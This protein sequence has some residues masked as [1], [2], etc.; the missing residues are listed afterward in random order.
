MSATLSSSAVA[1]INDNVKMW[2]R[3]TRNQTSLSDGGVNRRIDQQQS[4]LSTS[5][6]AIA[7]WDEAT[8]VELSKQSSQHAGKPKFRKH[9]KPERTES[10]PCPVSGC[11]RMFISQAELDN[12][13]DVQHSGNEE[14]DTSNQA[15]QAYLD[16]VDPAA[17]EQ[18]DLTVQPPELTEGDFTVKP[19]PVT[20]ASLRALNDSTSTDLSRS[21]DDLSI[22]EAHKS[23]AS[24]MS[25]ET[26][27]SV[28]DDAED[29]PLSE[30]ED[31]VSLT[32][33]IQLPVR[34]LLCLWMKLW[35]D[36][37]KRFTTSGT[38]Q[39]APYPGT[40]SHPSSASVSK[41]SPGTSSHASSQLSSTRSIKR[42]RSDDGD[43]DA[44]GRTNKTRNRR[45]Q[46]SP[47]N[48]PLACPFNKYDHYMFGGDSA[49]D[50]YHVCSTWN[51]VKTAYFK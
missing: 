50:K 37:S 17:Y 41:E 28:I 31:S 40:T 11:T 10:F 19:M 13:M 32:P 44:D 47:E 15:V 42:R 9:I 23:S 35:F 21:M 46:S 24:V 49:N 4:K 1:S 8:I 25:L 29:A 45:E 48:K 12:H 27:Y 51:D 7:F 14:L 30:Y 2:E 38:R 16:S 3:R 20:A 6:S 39:Q 43:D 18:A 34:M 33:R 26:T 36:L 22:S 5:K